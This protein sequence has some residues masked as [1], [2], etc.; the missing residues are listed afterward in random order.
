MFWKHLFCIIT[1]HITT[2]AACTSTLFFRTFSKIWS[3]NDDP[4][5]PCYFLF[6][7]TSAVSS[8]SKLY[9][10]D[11]PPSQLVIHTISLGFLYTAVS[12]DS[13]YHF[14]M[15]SV[16]RH[17]CVNVIIICIWICIYMYIYIHI[18]IYIYVNVYICI[19]CIIPA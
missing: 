13:R 12:S 8:L 14:Y 3:Y 18:Y 11:H 5:S 9:L 2:R 7:D 4:L 19:Y 6:W 17:V 1:I 10:Q 15:P 16:W